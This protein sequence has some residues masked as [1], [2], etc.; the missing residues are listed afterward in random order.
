MLGAF[1]DFH[2]AQDVSAHL[3]L[4]KHSLD[5][6]FQELF[7]VQLLSVA[8]PEAMKFHSGELRI[9]GVTQGKIIVASK[10]GSVEISA[11][12]FCLIP[13]RLKNVE[14]KAEPQTSFL[15]VEAN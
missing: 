3:A 6:D 10:N 12:D 9:I 11:G 2:L 13:A 8:S 4:G 5:R 14:I 15:C 7:R 1:I